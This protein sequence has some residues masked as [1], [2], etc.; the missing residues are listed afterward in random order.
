[1]KEIEKIV[2]KLELKQKRNKLYENNKK[3]LKIKYQMSDL[4]INKL[5]AEY[6]YN[7]N[8]ID[9]LIKEDTTH[10]LDQIDKY[11]TENEMLELN[12]KVKLYKILKKSLSM[13]KMENSEYYLIILTKL[14]YELLNLKFPEIYVYQGQSDTGC[15]YK[16][17]ISQSIC[18]N[19]GEFPQNI[20]IPYNEI[21]SNRK[22]RHFF[23]NVSFKYL[24]ELTN[25]YSFDLDSK[26]LGRVKIL[27][28]K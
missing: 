21:N 15:L 23:N 11:L 18:L 13:L 28:K 10:S 24:E 22:C 12:D 19:N 16:N 1:M 17:I 20:I 25:D 27:T 3:I 7:L 2:D 4:A 9:Y 26:K 8:I 14:R 5:V 6:A